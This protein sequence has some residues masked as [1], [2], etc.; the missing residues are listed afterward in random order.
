MICVTDVPSARGLRKAADVL[1]QVRII[2]PQRHF[3]LNRA[4]AKVDLTEE[5][6]ERTV[7]RDIDHRIP[8]SRSFPVAMNRGIPVLLGE[9]PGP[10]VDALWGLVGRVVSDEI[11][12]PG[13]QKRGGLF[14]RKGR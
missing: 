3:I 12:L 14:G 1:D 6:I 9:E 4:D 13:T 10:E 11:E 2:E 8:S 7:G 5:D